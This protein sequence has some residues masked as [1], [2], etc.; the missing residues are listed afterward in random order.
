M[1]VNKEN[2]IT[3]G[4]QNT[5]TQKSIFW[6]YSQENPLITIRENFYRVFLHHRQFTAIS[7]TKKND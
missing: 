6:Q 2:T 1:L 7:L 3:N 5:H 4:E